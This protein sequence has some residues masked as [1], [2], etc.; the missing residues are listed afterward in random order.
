MLSFIEEFFFIASAIKLA[1][2]QHREYANTTRLRCT[3]SAQLKTNLCVFNRL[4]KR[5]KNEFP[6]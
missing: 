6:L 1:P 3:V 2:H 4:L 5:V